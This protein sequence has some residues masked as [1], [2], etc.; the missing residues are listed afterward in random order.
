MNQNL[1]AVRV[2]DD[3]YWVG[4]IDW[5]I[6]DF[7]GYLTS[8]GTTYNAFL[9]MGEKITLVDGVKGPFAGEMLSRVAS[10][11][12][13]A[14][15]DYLVSNHS[16]MDHTGGLPQILAATRP[17]KVFAS[18]TGAKTLG[19]HFLVDQEITSVKDGE[20]LDLGNMNLAFVETKMLHWPDSMFSYL[21]ERGVLFS[22][23]A[24]GMHLASSQRFDDELQRWIL[25]HEAAK[26]YA[27]ILTPFSPLVLKLIEKVA[28]MNLDLKFICP[29]HGPIWRADRSRI[30]EQYAHWARQ[31]PTRKA[32]IVYDTMWQST[33]TMARAYSEGLQAGGACV[34]VL[35]VGETTHRSDVAT[36]LLEA[37]ALIVG[38]PTINNGLL[39]TVADVLTYLK[40]LKRR[41][42]IGA[43]FGSYGWSGESIGQVASTLEDMKV[44][45]VG[46]PLKVQYVPSETELSQCFEI[47]RQIGERLGSNPPCQLL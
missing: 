14:K 35:R 23:D 3:V 30:I 8:R 20:T 9:V 47:G 41:G 21:P 46:E 33:A 27:N 10:V 39:P 36:E 15:V 42:L 17:E 16:E 13:P 7:H 19:K 40:G 26:Y 4:A 29:D 34:N 5:N 28:G 2:T 22:Q 43:A 11:V 37:G 31:E 44:E 38:S 12:D 6:R 1:K 24:F 32:V 25:D 18:T 45:L